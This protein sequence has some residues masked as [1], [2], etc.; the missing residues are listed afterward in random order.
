MWLFYKGRALHL[1]FLF[2]NYLESH[3]IVDEVGVKVYGILL[4]LLMYA[5]D[6]VIFSETEEGLQE[7]LDNLDVY[8]R[9]G[10]ICKHA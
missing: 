2:V 9:K 8:C 3:F 10:D 7:G 1:Y 5:D 4:K 6:M